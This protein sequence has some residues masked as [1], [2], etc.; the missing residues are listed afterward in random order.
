MR[1]EVGPDDPEYSFPPSVLGFLRAI[2]PGDIKEEFRDEA[3]LVSM[4]EFCYVLGMERR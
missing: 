4:E 3:Y 1:A 2:C